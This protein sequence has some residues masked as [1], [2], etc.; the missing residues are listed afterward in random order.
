MS[1]MLTPLSH[2]VPA[3]IDRAGEY[4]LRIALCRQGGLTGSYFSDSFFLDQEFER[5]DRRASVEKR[6]AVPFIFC[7]DVLYKYLYTIDP[8][9]TIRQ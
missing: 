4:L 5:V 9:V 3:Q 8:I 6:G 1:A 7:F 2:G